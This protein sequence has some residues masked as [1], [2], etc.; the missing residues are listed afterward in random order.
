MCCL[1]VETGCPCVSPALAFLRE[2]MLYGPLES[3][4][5][6]NHFLMFSSLSC[7]CCR[8]LTGFVCGR[9]IKLLSFFVELFSGFV[10]WCFYVVHYQS[11][12]FILLMCYVYIYI[13]FYLFIKDIYNLLQGSYK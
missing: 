10:G 7:C 11:S 2:V 8:G 12:W 9:F 1:C 13:F 5:L 6:L 3:L 4:G